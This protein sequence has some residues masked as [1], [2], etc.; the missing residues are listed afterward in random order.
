MC[1]ATLAAGRVELTRVRDGNIHERSNAVVQSI[2]FHPSGKMLMSASY[3]K[4]LC[5][6]SVDGVRNPLIQSLFLEDLP[7]HTARF[8]AEGAQIVA[9]GRRR[10]F[11]VVDLGAQ[12]VERIKGIQGRDDASLERFVVPPASTTPADQRA[13]IAFLGNEGTIPL[14]SLRSKQLVGELCM[15]GSVRSAAFSP[16]G[17]QVY[18]AGGDGTVHIWDVRM[19]RCISRFVDEGC[20]E[21]TGLAVTGSLVAA[22]SRSGVVNVYSRDAVQHRMDEAEAPVRMPS[23]PVL[24][25]PLKCLGNLVTAVDTLAFSPDS[26]MLC[27]ASRMKKDALRLVHVPTL[28]TFSNWPTA[29]SPLHYVHCATFSPGGGFLAIGNAKGHVL[30]YR[31]H[32]YADV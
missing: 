24:A 1:R 16:D 2:E 25:H 19:R 11:Y 5:F 21:S 3:D 22:A 15:S 4:R 8:A 6:Y 28:T 32:H 20:V 23:T 7:I 17:V 26:Q 29:R 27:M 13:C 18:A 12:K 10:F 30:M 9:S 31:L 14:I